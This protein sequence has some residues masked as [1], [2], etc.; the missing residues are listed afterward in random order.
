MI[1]I[2]NVKQTS[3]SSLCQGYPDEFK[4]YIEYCRSLRFEDAPNYA[5]L[6]KLFSDLMK[7]KVNKMNLK[8]IHSNWQMMAFMIGWI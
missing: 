1:L 7:R 5:Y 3:I 2:L 4:T 8:I 6:R